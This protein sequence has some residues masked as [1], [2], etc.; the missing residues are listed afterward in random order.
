MGEKAVREEAR[1]MKRVEEMG[2][3][4]VGV[5]VGRVISN[6]G[7]WGGELKVSRE[8]GGSCWG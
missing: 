1:V 8:R 6:G 7:V 3:W 2:T 4:G 5:W